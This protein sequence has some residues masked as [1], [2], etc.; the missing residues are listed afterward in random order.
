LI[1]KSAIDARAALNVGLPAFSALVT[2]ALLNVTGDNTTYTVIFD[3]EIFDDGANYN[4]STGIFTAPVAGKYYFS[5]KLFLSDVAANHSQ[6]RCYINTT[7]R[8]YNLVDYWSVAL[9]RGIFWSC[10]TDMAAGDTAS[11]SI[12]ASG[13]SKVIDIYGE[14]NEPGADIYSCFSGYLIQ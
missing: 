14:A 8:N 1:T 5:A 13:G 11:V 2:S 9:Q 4:T 7:K 3:S 12:R 10:F 6:I